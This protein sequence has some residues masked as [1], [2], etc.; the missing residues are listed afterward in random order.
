[1]PAPKGYSHLQIALHWIA[2]LLIVQQFVFKDA[3]SAA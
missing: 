1:M 3:I 2:A